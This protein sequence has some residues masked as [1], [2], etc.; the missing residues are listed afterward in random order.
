MEGADG[1]MFAVI[2]VLADCSQQCVASPR[3]AAQWWEGCFLRA[4]QGKRK[5]RTKVGGVSEKSKP[6]KQRKTVGAIN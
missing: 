2:D 1:V 3:I 6:A 5:E 4:N